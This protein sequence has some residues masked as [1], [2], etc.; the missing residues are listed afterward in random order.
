MFTAFLSCNHHGCLNLHSAKQGKKIDMRS[1][2]NPVK[3]HMQLGELLGISGT[4]AI[5]LEDGELVPGYVPPK[6]LAALFNQK[7]N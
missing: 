4:P 5:L 6:R 3:D 2:E 1:C 7:D